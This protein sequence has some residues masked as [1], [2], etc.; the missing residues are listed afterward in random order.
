M[1]ACTYELRYSTLCLQTHVQEAG[2]HAHPVR[3]WRGVEVLQAATE[4][5]RL[6][7]CLC[8]H[9]HVVDRDLH[10]ARG[11]QQLTAHV[12]RSAAWCGHSRCRAASIAIRVYTASDPPFRLHFRMSFFGAQSSH[13]PPLVCLYCTLSSPTCLPVCT[14]NGSSRARCVRTIVHMIMA[15]Q[16]KKEGREGD[17]CRR[18]RDS[19]IGSA[20][21]G[22]TVSA[23][24]SRRGDAIEVPRPP[25]GLCCR[26]RPQ[27]SRTYA[28][29]VFC[30]PCRCR[31]C[32]SSP[33]Q[34]CRGGSAGEET[35]A[36]RGHGAR[37]TLGLYT[38]QEANIRT[39][40]VHPF[41][42]SHIRTFTI[43]TC[44]S[45]RQVTSMERSA[46]FYRKLVC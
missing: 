31:V 12:R 41:T 23:C 25:K 19:D 3:S 2:P 27:V 6:H 14:R 4:G 24:C 29:V 43:H 34:H 10:R 11:G 30:V 16:K 28:A 9:S 22:S 42:R 18:K 39:S 35:T 8:M 32:K 7:V 44:M 46:P 36:H 33:Q 37:H 1:T 26:P 5:L 15:A 13:Y 45:M 38:R 40:C 21:A 20:A 17:G